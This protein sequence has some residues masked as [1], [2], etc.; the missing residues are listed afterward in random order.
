ME[1]DLAKTGEKY[2]CIMSDDFGMHPAINEGIVKAF[3]EGLLTD[4][5]IMAPCPA[6]R[7]AAALARQAGLPVGFHATLTCDW[8][9]YRWGPITAAPSLR[10]SDGYLHTLVADAWA[11]AIYEEVKTEL[12]AQVEA[13]EA[14]GIRSTHASY[15]MGADRQNRLFTILGEIGST[16]TGPLRLDQPGE[17]APGLAAYRFDS[18]FCT[19]TWGLTYSDRKELL[20]NHLRDLD[21]GYHMWMVHAGA[22]HP[23]LDKLCS[24][25]FHA[26]H[27]ARPYRA[28]DFALLMDSEV[29]DWIEELGFRRI[30]VTDA[31]FASQ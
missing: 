1:P 8:N 27:W 31:P 14:E 30:A 17:K 23:D 13:I 25:D 5:N 16:R 11:N 2:L 3:C 22:D 19:S 6:F 15:H 9:L 12:L 24:A 26:F 21:A 28:L 29:K 10:A 4:T 20:M 7:E 18:A